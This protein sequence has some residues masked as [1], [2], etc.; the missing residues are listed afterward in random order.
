MW[1]ILTIFE[2]EPNLPDA[3]KK[4]CYQEYSPTKKYATPKTS[5]RIGLNNL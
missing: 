3:Y 5:S 1:T 4:V 2:A